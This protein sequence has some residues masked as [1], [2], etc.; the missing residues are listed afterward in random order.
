MLHPIESIP[1]RA[2]VGVTGGGEIPPDV[3]SPFC[4]E[5]LDRAAANTA[6]NNAALGQDRRAGGLSAVE[7]SRVAA[8]PAIATEVT[9]DPRAISCF[10]KSPLFGGR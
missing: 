5:I 3:D 8:L 1:V 2:L 4:T 7:R 9:S 6:A 10:A